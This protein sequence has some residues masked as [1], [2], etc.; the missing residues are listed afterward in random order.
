MKIR[1]SVETDL[2]A[3]LDINVKAFGEKEGPVVAGLV[4]A[5]LEDPSAEPRLSL[6]AVRE[7]KVIGH[8]LFTKVRIASADRSASILAPLAVHPDVQNQGIGSQLVREGLRLLAESGCELVFVLGHPGYYPRFG[9][10]PAGE[11]GFEA[12]Y[13]IPEEAA[14][15]WMVQELQPGVLEDV[16]GNVICA[17]ALNKPEYWAE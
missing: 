9:F 13:P 15:A 16:L 17:D 14:G 2:D 4:D 6:I 12:P 10:R 8:V 1:S 7:D 11:L 5:L 3:L